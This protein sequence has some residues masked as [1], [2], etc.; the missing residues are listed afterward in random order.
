M[1]R[2]Y[3]YMFVC[4]NRLNKFVSL[5]ARKKKNLQDSDTND[6]NI[7][8]WTNNHFLLENV[9]VSVRDLSD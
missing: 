4:E 3:A 1:C 2:V 5:S 9:L 8:Q 7:F 6:I